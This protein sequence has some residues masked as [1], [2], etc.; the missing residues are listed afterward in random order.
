MSTETLYTA[1]V[2]WERGTQPFLDMRYSRAHRWRFDNGLEVRATAS[3]HIVAPAL[4]DPSA[5]DP[6][7]AFV[8]ALSSCHMLWFLSIAATRRFCVDRYHDTASGIMETNPDGRLAITVV[9]L[10]PAVTFAGEQ[11]G[12][13]QIEAMHAEAHHACFIANSVKSEV[14]C[15]PEYGTARQQT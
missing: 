7:Q 14:R 10:R 13:E 12:R 9:T 11:P 15:L 1:N 2:I 4:T 3:P 6:E 5:L 8:A